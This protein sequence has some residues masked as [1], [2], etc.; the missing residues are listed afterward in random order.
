M[1]GLFSCE[2]ENAFATHLRGVAIEP[3]EEC[4]EWYNNGVVK[5]HKCEKYAAYAQHSEGP[6]DADFTRCLSGCT[7]G[8][9]TFDLVKPSGFEALFEVGHV[10]AVS[11][12]IGVNGFTRFWGAVDGGEDEATGAQGAVQIFDHF[13]IIAHEFECFGAD[14]EV[15]GIC[16]LEFFEVEGSEEEVCFFAV[17]DEGVA[18]ADAFSGSVEREHAVF[19]ALAADPIGIVAIP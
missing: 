4:C 3:I 19:L 15:E 5:G 18:A 10:V 12:G 16:A 8:K 14:D 11:N 2:D 9:M 17:A 1:S 7:P 13:V 6:V